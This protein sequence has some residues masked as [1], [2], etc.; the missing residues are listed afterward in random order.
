[1]PPA[2]LAEAGHVLI[3][4]SVDH[5]NFGGCVYAPELGCTQIALPSPSY[6]RSLGDTWQVRA[7]AGMRPRLLE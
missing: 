5:A 7:R 4:S 2:T 3:P 6:R 1:M